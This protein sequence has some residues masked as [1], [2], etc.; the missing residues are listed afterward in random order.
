VALNILLADD[1]VPAQNMGKKILSDAGYDVMTVSNGLEALRKIAETVPDIAILDIFMPGYTGLEIC[2]KLRANP[3]TAALP[4]ILTVGKLEP[5]RPED[6][7]HVHSNAII[8]KPFAAAE[9]IS[10]V[11]SLIGGAHAAS[12]AEAPEQAPADPLPSLASAS[13]VAPP[14]S[15]PVAEEAEDEPLFAYRPPE[16]Q[17][18]GDTGVNA[19]GTEPLGAAADAMQ[20]ASLVFNP[21]AKHTPFSASAVDLL[22]SVSAPVEDASSPFTEFDLEPAGSVYS[23]ATEST[24]ESEDL[25]LSSAAPGLAH[26]E[27]ANSPVLATP[28]VDPLLDVSAPEIPAGILDSNIPEVGEIGADE[29]KAGEPLAS[30]SEEVLT[31][32]EEARRKAF[33]DLFNSDDL[34]PLD[35]APAIAEAHAFD[36]DML[37]TI[38][39]ASR[40]EIVDVHPDPEIEPL[41]ETTPEAVVA[42][43]PDPYLMDEEESKS[44]V[45][46]IPGRDVL[47][48]ASEDS[49]WMQT[50]PTE[51]L[52]GFS[53]EQY[54]REGENS[55]DPLLQSPL[56]AIVPEAAATETEAVTHDAVAHVA[57]SVPVEAPVEARPEP[58]SSVKPEEILEAPAESVIPETAPS[59]QPIER[60]AERLAEH[61]EPKPAEPQPVEPEPVVQ[62]ESKPV[63]SH[64]AVSELAALA[65]GAG[66]A[67]ALPKL[68]HLVEREIKHAFPQSEVQQPS[69][70]TAPVSEDLLSEPPV[71]EIAATVSAPLAPEPEVKHEIDVTPALEAEPVAEVA[72]VPEA[73]HE[74]EVTPPVQEAEP[75]AEVTRVL[76]QPEVVQPAPEAVPETAAPA[77]PPPAA[78]QS[79]APAEQK[80]VPAEQPA[81]V[82]KTI[83]AVETSRSTEAERVHQAV[84]RVFDRFKPLLVAAIVRELARRD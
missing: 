64:S 36:S 28:P 46:A 12:V 84:E 52:L 47:L 37:P 34:P 83:P 53:G 5:Y 22:P 78:E 38:A 81:A 41:L 17:S 44:V 14:S 40:H 10:A 62:A 29:T 58:L 74:P 66:L 82:S 31:P 42:A 60:A 25:P 4:V 48:E 50:Q 26:G 67:A 27:E 20:P 56:E 54:F 24:S 21:D 7:E 18:P 15:G 51:D 68:A 70:E 16:T 39:G 23:S 11:R 69:K 71:A 77:P 30:A 3:K 13:A 79:V 63:E 9:L 43:E 76:A 45:G 2:E 8:V 1:S 73:T 65:S 49:G 6:G 33:E 32:E 72:P 75:V 59:Q 61:A 57:A 80:Q 19:Y 55:V 35:E